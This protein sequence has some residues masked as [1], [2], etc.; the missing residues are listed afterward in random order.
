M[1]FK[2]ADLCDAFSDRIQ[3]AEPMLSDFGG[4]E[5]FSGGI[6]TVKT[7][8]DNSK[9][10]STLETP[11]GGRVLVVDG[12]GSLRC[13]LLGDNLAQ[14]AIDNGWS[15]VIVNG[16]IRDSGDIMEM[17]LGVKAL[18]THP[19]KSVKAG[20]GQV[21]VPVTFAGV[22]FRRGDFL[23]AD[24]DGVILSEKALSL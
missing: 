6:E 5:V 15:G 7:F 8:E 9:V 18:G 2:T 22:L 17:D 21:G 24:E 4:R 11:G 1:N 19:L 20:L 14:L 10:R 13:A 12:G 16:C 23:Y 3:I